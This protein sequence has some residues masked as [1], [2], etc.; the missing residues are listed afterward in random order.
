MDIHQI[1]IT[2][3]SPPP[4]KKTPK[5]KPPKPNEQTEGKPTPLTQTQ[6]YRLIELF[7]FFITPSFTVILWSFFQVFRSIVPYPG[8][9]NTDYD[10]LESIPIVQHDSCEPTCTVKPYNCN[11]LQ[12]FIA[13]ECRCMCTNRGDVRCAPN[14]VWDEDNCRCKCAQTIDNCPGFSRFSDSTCRWVFL[15]RGR[16]G[17]H[18]KAVSKGLLIQSGHWYYN[19]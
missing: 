8:S 3:P 1:L 16:V 4:K 12:T 7:F 13:R 5:D 17:I 9:P 15:V 18:G 2:P 6:N 11:P 10:V 19:F 14:Q